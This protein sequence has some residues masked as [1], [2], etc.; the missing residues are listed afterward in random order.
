MPN[1]SRRP[2]ASGARRSRA[3]AGALLALA[4]A[5]AS[6]GAQTITFDPADFPTGNTTPIP[7]GYGAIPGVETTF[8][9]LAAFHDSAPLG[10][11]MRWWDT[12][13]GALTG[14]AYGF[15][16]PG[17]VAEVGI[18][19]LVPGTTISLLDFE[20]GSWLTRQ[21]GLGVF[22]LGWDYT[23]LVVFDGLVGP[24][25]F[26]F[27]EYLT[28]RGLDA[29]VR[30]DGF[31]IQWTQD[32]S[33][34][35]PEITGRGAYDAAIDNIVYVGPGAMTPVPEPGTV[36]LLATG[37]GAVGLVGARRRRRARSAA[38]ALSRD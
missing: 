17:S 25:H 29:P 2:A 19:N 3:L 32:A 27:A 15:N 31:R 7:D 22:V 38:S 9:T 18:R 10:N 36:V 30:E 5:A 35:T 34:G 11:G 4:L 6:A 37:L 24:T 12:G 20:I 28:A 21:R 26:S 14:V 13:H 16:S 1:P 8:R 33:P 23:P